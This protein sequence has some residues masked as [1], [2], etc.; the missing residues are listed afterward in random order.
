MKTST[1]LSLALLLGAAIIA[2]FV[3]VRHDSV[4]VSAAAAQDTAVAIPALRTIR[5][6]GY[7][8]DLTMREQRDFPGGTIAFEGVVTNVLAP[9]HV[10]TT[11]T[12]YVYTP[13]EVTVSKMHRGPRPA[14]G[15]VILRAFGGTANGLKYEASFAPSEEIM[16]KGV[17]LVVLGPDPIVVVGDGDMRA[18]T[19]HGIHVVSGADLFDVT[20]SEH[21]QGHEPQSL[22]LTDAEEM[23]KAR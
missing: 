2:G 7:L 8:V 6:D 17:R 15:K 23:L 19:P 16:N 18:M 3:A 1:K 11:A 5:A 9:R 21:H 4:I 13:L 22:R 12:E 14:H 10:R 20:H